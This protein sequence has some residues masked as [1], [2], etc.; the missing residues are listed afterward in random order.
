MVKP[1][2]SD[3]EETTT[4]GGAAS[5]DEESKGTH[6]V[7]DSLESLESYSGEHTVVEH[8]PHGRYVRFNVRLGQGAYKEVWKAYDTSE[9]VEVSWNTLS[10]KTIPKQDRRRV[11]TELK[12]LEEVSSRGIW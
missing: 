8:S 7:A 9:G 3:G 2:T 4:G 10:L 11:I 12:I 1:G 6:G 5:G